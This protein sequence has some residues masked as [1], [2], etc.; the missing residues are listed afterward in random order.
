MA[1]KADRRIVLAPDRSRVLGP[2]EPQNGILLAAAG[3]NV[4]NRDCERYGLGPWAS[5]EAEE[6]QIVDPDEAEAVALG[7]Q[8]KGS[9]SSRTPSP[10]KDAPAA[11]PDDADN[12]APTLGGD[13]EPEAAQ[14]DGGGQEP[15][16][17]PGHPITP[18]VDQET[19]NAQSRRQG[20]RTG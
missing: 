15:A 14:G 4:S 11:G 13:P 10:P 6:V 2:D 8:P 18:L 12:D 16:G 5:A 1:W 20:G 7:G 9:R 19:R 17:D 3:R